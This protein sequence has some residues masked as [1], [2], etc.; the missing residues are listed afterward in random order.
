MLAVD[1]TGDAQKFEEVQ[2]ACLAFEQAR[3]EA[4]D[5]TR[6]YTEPIKRNGLEW[7]VLPDG[8]TY[9]NAVP[10]PDEVTETVGIVDIVLKVNE[11]KLIEARDLDKKYKE[12]GGAIF[13]TAQT[14]NG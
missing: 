14:I 3:G 2:A 6:Y 10:L 5:A 13:E 1:V 7:V 9:K 12:Q 8:F 4:K 11:G